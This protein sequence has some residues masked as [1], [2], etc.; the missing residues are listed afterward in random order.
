MASTWLRAA[1]VEMVAVGAEPL[2]PAPRFCC[3]MTPPYAAVG[4]RRSP[5]R[6]TGAPGGRQAHV[7]AEFSR[8]RSLS[9][10]F[11]P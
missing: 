4:E 9:A 11:R 3:V 10:H 5:G 8:E 7:R 1:G 2:P 6:T